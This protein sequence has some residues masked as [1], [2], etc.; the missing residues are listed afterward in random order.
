MK[1]HS[2][3]DSLVT[4]H[5]TG[6]FTVICNTTAVC[7]DYSSAT[8]MLIWPGHLF[9]YIYIMAVCPGSFHTA[10]S[11][12]LFELFVSV[13]ACVYLYLCV[14][15]NVRV[16]MGAFLTWLIRQWRQL[17]KMFLIWIFDTAVF[18]FFFAVVDSSWVDDLLVHVSWTFLRSI[19]CCGW[20]LHGFRWSRGRWWRHSFGHWQ[21]AHAPTRSVY[22]CT[23]IDVTCDVLEWEITVLANS[24]R[25]T[26]QQILCFRKIE[27]KGI[28][29]ASFF[30]CTMK[31]AF[32]W[33]KTINSDAQK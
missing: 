26:T 4:S 22:S 24:L 25:S 32:V 30:I 33:H 2:W 20:R 29:A 11:F 5:S 28:F 3:G 10:R 27:E 6:L 1:G 8:G 13:F 23:F 14:C 16:W 17:T 31:L 7:G 15:G 21:R 12:L 18:T 9:L 19:G